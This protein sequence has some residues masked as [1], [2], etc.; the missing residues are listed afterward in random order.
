MWWLLLGFLLGSSS[1]SAESADLQKYRR[2]REESLKQN[3]LVVVGLTWLKD[4]ANTVAVARKSYVHPAIYTDK[5]LKFF[6]E[7]HADPALEPMPRLTRAET[8][9]V[10][11]LG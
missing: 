7:R 10:E 11:F 1:V 2:E 6:R 4:G 8:A 9:L 3:W 5:A